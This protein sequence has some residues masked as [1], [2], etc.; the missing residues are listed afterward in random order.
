MKQILSKMFCLLLLVFSKGKDR[1]EF[2]KCFAGPSENSRLGKSSPLVLL[3]HFNIPLGV[4]FQI[5]PYQNVSSGVGVVA[6]LVECLPPNTHGALIPGTT[7]TGR[8][9][10]C[11]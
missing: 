5:L 4:V 6:Q 9:G 8:G 11:Q 3:T 2:P 1:R 7:E 10:E